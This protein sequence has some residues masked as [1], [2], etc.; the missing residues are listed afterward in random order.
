MFLFV[1]V[2]DS[3]AKASIENARAAG[4]SNVDV[5][6]FPCPKC[7]NASGQVKDMGEFHLKVTLGDMHKR[8]M[9]MFCNTIII[10]INIMSILIFHWSEVSLID[11]TL[12]F[13]GLFM[14]C[15]V[16]LLL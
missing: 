8:F 3:N 6:M 10:L 12:T 9:G 14:L 4:I 2:P 11:G 16:D 5:Y 7:G 15:V 1:G 13:L